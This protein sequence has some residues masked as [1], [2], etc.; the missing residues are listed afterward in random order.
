MP[1]FLQLHAY[2]FIDAYVEALSNTNNAF[3]DGESA[4]ATT[5]ADLFIPLVTFYR[6][7][8]IF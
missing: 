8:R 7:S 6:K 1:T 3:K 2:I 5:P 4:G